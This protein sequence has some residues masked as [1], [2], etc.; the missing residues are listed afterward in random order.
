MSHPHR[1]TGRVAAVVYGSLRD[2]FVSGSFAQGTRLSVESIRAEFSVSKQPV[3]EALRVLS[4][5]GLVEIIPQVGS[6]ARSYPAQ[7]VRDFYDV[8][9]GFEGAIAAA[10]AERRSDAQLQNLEDVSARIGRLSEH[11]DPAVRS[12]DYRVM[13]R[14]LHAIVHQMSGSRVMTETSGRMWDLSDYLLNSTG[15][16]FP[17]ASVTAGRHDEHEAIRS[18]ISDRDADR[19]RAEMMRHIADTAKIIFDESNGRASGY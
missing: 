14:E 5:D 1:T 9:A 10:A 19:A 18:A 7:E 12:R 6:I 3:M 4:A 8:F 16:D 13:N 2:R 15:A 11:P 17:L